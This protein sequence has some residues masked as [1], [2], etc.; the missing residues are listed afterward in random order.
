M[1]PSL[2]RGAPP[3]GRRALENARVKRWLAVPVGLALVMLALY[4]LVA[5]GKGGPPLDRIDDDSRARLERVLR[6]DSG[7]ERR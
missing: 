6:E 5:G 2:R 3:R 7:R 4:V 1:E